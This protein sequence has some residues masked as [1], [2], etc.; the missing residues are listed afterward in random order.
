MNT[1]NDNNVD[2][3]GKTN[4]AEIIFRCFYVSWS[5]WL[6]SSLV[7]IYLEAV[8]HFFYAIKTSNFWSYCAIF[9]LF[10]SISGSSSLLKDGFILFHDIFNCMI[11]LRQFLM[12]TS[13]LIS[14]PCLH[15]LRHP[16]KYLT[17]LA[18]LLGKKLISM[19]LNKFNIDSLLFI[20]PFATL[21][22]LSRG[23]GL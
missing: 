9:L 19:F 17:W 3:I 18:N 16:L 23:S 21:L 12:M 15:F 14:S 13:A 4:I 22:M 1:D 11:V 6:D 20:G 8:V 2:D 7:N 10:C 5:I